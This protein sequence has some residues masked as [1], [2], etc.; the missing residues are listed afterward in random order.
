MKHLNLLGAGFA[1][2]V[3]LACNLW[4]QDSITIQAPP[5]GPGPEGMAIKMVAEASFDQK[6]VTQ[7]PYSADQTTTT[8]QTLADGNRI[9]HTSTAKTY[10]DEQGRTRI[11][12]SFEHIGPVAT[13]ET[14]TVVSINDPVA[15]VRY[16]LQP[17]NRTAQKLSSD[18]DGMKRKLDAKQRA[19]A[20]ASAAPGSTRKTNVSFVSVTSTS[21]GPAGGFIYRTESSSAIN[22]VKPVTEDL[23]VQTM[24]GL[25]AKGTRTTIVIPAGAEGNE[26]PMQIV[27]ERWYS[28]DLQI[29]LKTVH[30]DP[31]MG[32]TV[33]TLSNVSRSNPDPSLFQVP[34][35]YQ[36]TD[37]P[38]AGS[39]F[40]F[41]S[42]VPPPPPPPPPAN[43]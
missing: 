18:L 34:S 32:E 20:V 26:R 3:L 16:E 40:V 37:S 1:A 17:D 19:E 6:A 11:E 29:A 30:T 14:H 24:E 22:G 23:G 36:L 4:A 35:D 5:P 39:R 15:G 8:T 25:Q 33:F 12:R 13:S 41:R 38:A 21:D 42:A 10:R 2:G 28:P 43:Q 27:D 31:R 7:A 9:V